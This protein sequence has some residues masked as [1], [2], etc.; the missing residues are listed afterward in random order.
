MIQKQLPAGVHNISN[1]SKCEIFRT[2]HISGCFLT[3]IRYII[4]FWTLKILLLYSVCLQG[5]RHRGAKKEK[6]ETKGKKKEFQD[7]RNEKS[8]GGGG[9]GGWAFIKKY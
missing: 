6:K 1:E 8:Y 2:D 4:F 9:E 3:Y 5:R 7:R